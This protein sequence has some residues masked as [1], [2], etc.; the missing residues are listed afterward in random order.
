[1]L[2]VLSVHLQAAYVVRGWNRVYTIMFIIS[3]SQLFM[4]MYFQAGMPKSVFHGDVYNEVI[5]C[6]AFLLRVLLM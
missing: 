5:L 3:L 6:P 2:T 1:M 4:N